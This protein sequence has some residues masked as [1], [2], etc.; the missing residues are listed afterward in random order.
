MS[1]AHQEK[2]MEDGDAVDLDAGFENEDDSAERE[3]AHLSP[4]KGNTRLSKAVSVS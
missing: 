3:A 4:V 2:E 1:S